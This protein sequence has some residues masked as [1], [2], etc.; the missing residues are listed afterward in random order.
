MPQ[1]ARVADNKADCLAFADS[2]VRRDKAHGVCHLDIDRAIGLLFDSGFSD[3]RLVMVMPACVLASCSRQGGQI[4][5]SQQG[6]CGYR[7]V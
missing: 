6:H 7:N 1:Y 3:C 4:Q 5:A 2:N